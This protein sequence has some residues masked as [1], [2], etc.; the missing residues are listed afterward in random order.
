MKFNFFYIKVTAQYAQNGRETWLFD[1]FFS[2]GIFSGC[3][4]GTKFT[5]F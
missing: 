3:V 2:V 4:S 1:S 5:S